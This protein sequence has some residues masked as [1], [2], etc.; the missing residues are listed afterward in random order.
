MAVYLMTAFVLSYLLCVSIGQAWITLDRRSRGLDIGLALARPAEY[1]DA[2]ALTVLLQWL[3]GPWFYTLTSRT[4]HDITRAC[5][6]NF[7]VTVLYFSI[8]VL[9]PHHRLGA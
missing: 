9:P 1:V 8:F 7:V 6:T 4:I 5:A 2:T 3:I